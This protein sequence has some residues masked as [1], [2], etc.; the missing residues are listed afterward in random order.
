MTNYTYTLLTENTV[1]GINDDQLELFSKDSIHAVAVQS[2]DPVKLNDKLKSSDTPYVLGAD[3]GGD[4][5]I[6]RL[7]KVIDGN[8]ETQPDY[9]AKVQGDNGEGYLRMLEEAS[10]YATEHDIPMG[11]SWGGP[12]D[13]SKPLFHPKAKTFLS[14]LK[15]KYGG[16]LAAISPFIR[17]V[18]NDGPAGALSGALEAYRKFSATDSV[19]IINGGGI[20]TSVIKNGILYSA[21]A[22]HVEGIKALNPY[23]QDTACGVYDNQFTCL[24]RLGANKAGIEAQWQT[25][26]GENMRA[27]DIEDRYKEGRKLAEELYDHSA[28]VIAHVLLGTVKAMAMDVTDSNTVIIGHGGAFKFPYYGERIRQ[29]LEHH[30]DSPIQLLMTKD[31]GAEDSNACLDGA[32]IAALCA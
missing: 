22:G 30:Y 17:A 19:F 10:I 8:L 16:D 7:F 29:I 26:T 2:V 23:E 9:E 13:G 1:P 4:K 24:E 27:R 6:V 14:E 31:F 21:E 28:L 15:E 11:I 12:L 5:G 20:G 25:L 3:M 32:A 18:M